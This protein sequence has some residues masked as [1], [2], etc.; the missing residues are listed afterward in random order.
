MAPS[1]VEGRK[2]SSEGAEAGSVPAA[3]GV[4]EAQPEKPAVE[5]EEEGDESG[6]E[7][8][9]AGGAA[10]SEAKKK[11]KSVCSKTQAG[12]RQFHGAWPLLH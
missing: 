3:N 1:E 2:A 12:V 5:N 7:E 9:E 8:E 6:E 11:K 4:P 10:A